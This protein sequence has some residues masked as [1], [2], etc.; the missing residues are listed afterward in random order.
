MASP[1]FMSQII[2]SYLCRVRQKF[3]LIISLVFLVNSTKAQIFSALQNSN[4]SGVN[5]I[6]TN[7]A[8]VAMMTHKRSA[9]VG[10]IG[11]DLTN[12][13]FSLEAPFSLWKLITGGVDDKYRNPD[14]SIDWQKKWLKEDL[15]RNDI[16]F[17]LSTEFRG[18]SYVNHYGRFVWGTATRTRSTLDI[19]GLSTGAWS[20][21]RQWL[22]SQKLESPLVII[23]DEF[24]A[25][26]NSYQELSAVLAAKVV[27]GERFKLGIGTTLKGILGLGSV[28][29]KNNG[30]KFNGIGMDTVEVTSGYMEVA[31]TDNSI[32][33]QL[34][35]GVLSG[36][37]PRLSEIHGLGF[38]MDAGIS[39]EFGNDMATGENEQHTF[40]DYKFK[41]AASVT[42]IG[43]IGYTNANDGFIKA[44]KDK[45]GDERVTNDPMEAHYIG[46]NM[47]VEAATKAGTTDVDAVRENMYGL[48]F[49]NLTGGMAEML[50][51]H[52][53]AKP[54]LI[55]EIQEDGQFD[56]I[57]QTTEVP[58]DAWT[59]FLPESKVLVS[60]WKELKCGMFNTATETC[61]Q[62]KSI[63]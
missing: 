61:V 19:N 12:D 37:L 32:L 1:F 62:I 53:L 21:G 54:V 48:T 7:P 40:R 52:H 8:Q 44:W 59:D 43:Q 39:M 56:I 2:C 30:I 57:S 46:F 9:T 23:S 13:Y 10:V 28:N 25:Q 42:D 3:V 63:Y 5:L 18:P 58:G 4:F 47:W 15:N 31:Y 41:V 27:D 55:G 20:W 17:N 50:P 34:F 33:R 38:G 24:E 26:A 29:I 16:N 11:Y 6:Y 60:D 51:N 36:G 22:D 49:P 45:M 35:S 14:G